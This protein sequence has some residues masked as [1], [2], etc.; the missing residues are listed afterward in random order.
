M[1]SKVE[2]D[3][4]HLAEERKDLDDRR[5]EID[6]EFASLEKLKAHL[7]A[8]IKEEKKAG[9]SANETR[10][11]ITAAMGITEAV[12]NV[13]WGARG[14]IVAPTEVRDRMVG[15]GFKNTRNLLTEIHAALRRLAQQREIHKKERG[16]KKGYMGYGPRV[17]THTQ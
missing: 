11:R 13:V 16:G 5:A 12:R 10:F 1:K 9:A 6:R 2:A 7:D 17:A 3:L 14:R 8:C 15:V 4:S